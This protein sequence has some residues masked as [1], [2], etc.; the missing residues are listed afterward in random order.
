VFLFILFFIVES[1]SFIW[2]NEKKCK[3]PVSI[4]FLN[5]NLAHIRLKSG[6][7]ENI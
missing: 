4:N 5:E 3:V 7:I 6:I 1:L 2:N